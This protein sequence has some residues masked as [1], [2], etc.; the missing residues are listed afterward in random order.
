MT[1][2][3]SAATRPGDS[4]A[5]AP[6]VPCDSPLPGERG[7]GSIAPAITSERLLKATADNWRNP[8]GIKQSVR[9]SVRLTIPGIPIAKGRPRFV[10]ATGRTFTPEKTARFENLVRLVASE[11]MAECAQAVF[12]GPVRVE[13]T[14]LFPIAASWPRLKR[15]AAACG[16]LLHTSRPDA[17]NI[18]K[19]VLDA[20][21]EIVWRDDSQVAKLVIEKRYAAEPMTLVWVRSL[22]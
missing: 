16:T 22:P 8:S 6:D 20:C 14:A 5:T 4:A 19:A 7:R 2:A 15:E 3:S 12:D 17:E 9:G 11:T 21:N 18:A 13:I 10:R 1:H